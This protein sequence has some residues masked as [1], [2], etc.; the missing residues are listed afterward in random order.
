MKIVEDQDNV[1]VITRGQAKAEVEQC[2]ND[3]TR[4]NALYVVKYNGKLISLSGRYYKYGYK[5]MAN[6]RNA[7]SQK[8]GADLAHA[9]VENDV[10][11]LEKVYM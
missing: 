11:Q 8:F 5:T 3:V 4:E 1:T 9:L 6:L 10:I 7:L 2:I